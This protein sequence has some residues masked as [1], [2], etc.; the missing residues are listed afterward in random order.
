MHL[1]VEVPARDPED[2]EVECDPLLVF[3]FFD[4]DAK[5]YGLLRVRPGRLPTGEL[6]GFRPS[7]W[8][9]DEKDPEPC[10]PCGPSVVEVA[11]GWLGSLSDAGGRGGVLLCLRG[12]GPAIRTPGVSGARSVTKRG[13]AADPPPKAAV[14]RAFQPHLAALESRFGDLETTPA[15]ARVTPP[16]PV[17]M[18]PSVSEVGIAAPQPLPPQLIGGP[19]RPAARATCGR[20]RAEEA[21][22]GSGQRLARLPE[23][24]ATLPWTSRGKSCRTGRSTP[25]RASPVSLAP[26]GYW[27][28]SG[29]PSRTSWGSDSGILGRFPAEEEEGARPQGHCEAFA[30]GGEAPDKVRPPQLPPGEGPALLEWRVS[31][32]EQ[33]VEFERF[34]RALCPVARDPVR[35]ELQPRAVGSHEPAEVQEAERSA[36]FRF[37]PPRASGAPAAHLMMQV[38]ERTLGPRTSTGRIPPCGPKSWQEMGLTKELLAQTP[39]PLVAVLTRGSSRSPWRRGPVEQASVSPTETWERILRSRDRHELH[40]AWCPHPAERRRAHRDHRRKTT[41]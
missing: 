18:P 23:A 14:R 17:C 4:L 8:S 5:G 32:A 28:R 16:G 25:C 26:G 10:L 21:E 31:L 19:W 39:V 12:R 11:Q 3:R 27:T 7:G 2:F 15:P 30:E 13:S 1:A 20:E 22:T 24:E 6:V 40:Y 41:V 35:R 38:R 36:R 37:P 34:R 9:G 33:S 29:K